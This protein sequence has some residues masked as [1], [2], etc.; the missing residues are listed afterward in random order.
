M[1]KTKQLSIQK[2]RIEELFTRAGARKPGRCPE[3]ALI[4]KKWVEEVFSYISEQR[5]EPSFFS[6]FQ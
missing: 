2:T 3:G 5:K 6:S 1:G 4:E